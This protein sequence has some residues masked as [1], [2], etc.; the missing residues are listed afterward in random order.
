MKVICRILMVVAALMLTEANA[1]NL[2][3]N[4]AQPHGK[5]IIKNI[6]R[7]NTCPETCSRPM[8]CDQ[9]CERPPAVGGRMRGIS[10]SSCKKYCQNL[11]ESH[12]VAIVRRGQDS[13]E[14]T[15]VNDRPASPYNLLSSNPAAN[16]NNPSSS[17]SPPVSSFA[18][19]IQRNAGTA[20]HGRLVIETGN[21]R[22]C[23][24]GMCC[25]C[26]CFC[27]CLYTALSGH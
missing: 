13:A 15:P 25:L 22:N 3:Y 16:S 20:R 2:N 27:G 9:K 4:E 1:Q 6:Q 12:D 17:T 10:Q 7:S 21:R 8:V 26:S 5:S 14:S 24:H 23:C 19:E 11:R 18:I